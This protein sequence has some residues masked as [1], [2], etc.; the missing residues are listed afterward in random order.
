MIGAIL[1]GTLCGWLSDR[2]G[3]RR[4]MMG[5]LVVATAM[6]PLWAFADPYI[7]DLTLPFMG[8]ERAQWIYPIGSLYRSGAVVAFGSDWSSSSN[9]K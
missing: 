6:V 3:R 2:I 4:A 7:T 8:K 9:G 5:S 1:G